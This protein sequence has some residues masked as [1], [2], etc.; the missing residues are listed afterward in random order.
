MLLEVER[1]RTEFATRRG[2]ATAVDDVSFSL[3]E[4]ETLALVGESGCGKSATALSLM[5]LI[6]EPGTVSGVVRLDGVDLLGLGEREMREVRGRQLAMVFQDP[7]TSLNP[8][9]K[10]GL[11]ITEPLRTHLG[12]SRA[13]ARARAA[14]LLRLVGIPEAERRLGDYPHQF[15]GGMRQRVMIAIALACSPRLILADEITTALDV[16]IQAQVLE[17]LKE[18]IGRTGA[19]VLLITHDLGVV[20]GMADRVNVMY[21]G[22]I[23][24]TA[25]TEELYASPAMP[26]TWGLLDSVPRTDREPTGRLVP[27]E[28]SPPDLVELPTGCRFRARCR[29]A[30][31]I[32]AERVP[33][34]ASVPSEHGVH[35]ARCWGTAEGGWL[36]GSDRHAALEADGGARGSGRG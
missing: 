27:I 34:L 28:G 16:T 3:R 13:E 19:A 4:G 36:V 29:F 18:L 20:A 23:V 22:Q 6:A 33:D 8:A 25:T 30:R 1:L 35:L 2:V 21:A 14:E 15:S 32:C 31:D 9:L 10:V 17:L 5:R 7:M 24:E 11:Q 26:Y 12:L